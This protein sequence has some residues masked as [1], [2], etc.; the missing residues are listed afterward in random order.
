MA[1]FINSKR[2]LCIHTWSYSFMDLSFC[3][4]ELS[5]YGVFIY[6]SIHGIIIHASIYEV[7][8]CLMYEVT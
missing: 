5:M 6:V 4:M 2:Y 1:L 7:I 8:N 3:C